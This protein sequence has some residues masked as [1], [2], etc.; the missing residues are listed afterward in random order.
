[1]LESALDTATRLSAGK[2]EVKGRRKACL[3]R[4]LRRRQAIGQSGR[5]TEGDPKPTEEEAERGEGDEQGEAEQEHGGETDKGFSSVGRLDHGPWALAMA[6]LH[7]S[8]IS[9]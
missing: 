2:Q 4:R 5:Q 8:A 6:D 9:R 3:P 1:M 7:W